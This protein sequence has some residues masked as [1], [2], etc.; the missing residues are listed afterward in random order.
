MRKLIQ[1]HLILFGLL[2][3]FAASAS[4]AWANT[5]SNTQIINNATLVYNNG[6]GVQTATASVIVTVALSP[7]SPIITSGPNQT[8]PYTGPTTLLKNS[9]TVTATSNGPDTY[10]ITSAITS[11]SNTTSPTA[12]PETPSITLGATVTTLG[13]STSVLNVPSDGVSGTKVN[14]IQGGET[15]V[16][17]G[18]TVCSVTSVTNSGSGV[19]T[20]TISPALSAAPGAGVQVGQQATIYVD[21][22]AGTLGT[23][24]NS[25]TIQKTATITSTTSG[26][27]T[28]TSSAVTDTYTSGTATLTK[29]VRNTVTSSGTGTPYVYGGNNYYP[30]GVIAK[31]TDTLE[32]LLVSNNNGTGPVT[33]SAVSDVLPIAYV[34]LKLNA[35]ASGKEVTYVNESG[36]ATTYSAAADSDQATYVTSTGTLTVYIGDGA[37]SSAGGSIP[38]GSKVLVLYQA[39]VN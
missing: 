14:G 9:F 3:V 32:Y 15:V 22:N 17:G 18:T 39:T 16:V 31:P 23:P 27:A 28:A 6:A 12:T 25:I 35:Y 38:G 33:A 7:A 37:T 19:A 20:I 36:V 2:V 5:A 26:T 11:Q 29:Y 34:T 30:T 24:G 10:N 1:N 4:S 21:V 8:T 13:S